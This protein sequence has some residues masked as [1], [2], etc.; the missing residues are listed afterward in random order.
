[1]STNT[2]VSMTNITKRFGRVKALDDFTINVESGIFGLVGPNGAGKTTILR[3]LL[4]LIKP[5][6]GSAQ[7]LGMDVANGPERFLG[8]VGVLHEN[9]Y[10]PPS[11][12]PT[13]YLD[14]IA[15]LY[16]KSRS[17]EELLS[18]VELSNAADRKIKNLSAGMYRRLG[19]AQA[20]VGRPSLVFLDEPTSNLDV[21]GRDLIVQ[22]IINIEI[23]LKNTDS[24]R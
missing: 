9:P 14:T 19:I 20:L 2:Q 24:Y 3:V 13:E 22:L 8:Q 6:K 18:L 1:M 10:Y 5:D 15:S 17:A 11:L 12:T 16:R 7:V 4:G 21:R 23:Y